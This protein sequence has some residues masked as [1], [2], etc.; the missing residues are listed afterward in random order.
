MKENYLGGT[1]KP[2]HLEQVQDGPAVR[3]EFRPLAQDENT[4]LA[5]NLTVIFG[6]WESSWSD[7][8]SARMASASEEM[9]FKQSHLALQPPRSSLW[10]TVSELLPVTAQSELCTNHSL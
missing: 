3:G 1:V 6:G 10:C 7:I 8:L 9:L 4:Y 5:E 2:E